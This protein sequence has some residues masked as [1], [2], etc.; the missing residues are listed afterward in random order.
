MPSPSSR[1]PPFSRFKADFPPDLRRHVAPWRPLPSPLGLRTAARSQVAA[2]VLD[3]IA[4]AAQGR[5]VYIHCSTGF[6]RTATVGALI[7][8]LGHKLTGTHALLLYQVRHS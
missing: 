5:R 8:G 3:I 6:Q 7:L 2:L 4:Y 1:P